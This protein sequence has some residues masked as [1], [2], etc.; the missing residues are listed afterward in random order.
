MKYVKVLL[1]DVQHLLGVSLRLGR[2]AQHDFE[3]SGQ[4]EFYGSLVVLAAVLV[5]GESQE[6][7]GC[8]LFGCIGLVLVVCCLFVIRLP[9]IYQLMDAG[10]DKP[11]ESVR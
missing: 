3:Q 6:G 11:V 10:L 9:V 1:H 8:I 7:A 2:D 5:Q 4:R